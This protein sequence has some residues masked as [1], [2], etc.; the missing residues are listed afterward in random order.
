[1]LLWKLVC[2]PLEREYLGV[3]GID[4]K[5]TLTF[6]FKEIVYEVDIELINSVI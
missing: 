2:H 5:I 6:I 3:L 1:M 4:G